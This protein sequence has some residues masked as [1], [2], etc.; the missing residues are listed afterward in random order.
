MVHGRL[1]A[2]LVA[3]AACCNAGLHAPVIGSKCKHGNLLFEKSLTF[4][5]LLWQNWDIF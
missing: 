4:L 5:I 3:M 1:Q 2:G